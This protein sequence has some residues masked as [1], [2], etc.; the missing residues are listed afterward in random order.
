MEY[1][2][3]IYVDRLNARKRNGLVKVITGLRRSGKSYLLNNLFHRSL[4]ESGVDERHIIKFA[5]DSAEDL[6]IIGEDLLDLE[7]KNSKVDPRKFLEFV[8]DRLID[9]GQYYILL[10]E[11][12]NLESFES[13]LNSYLRKDNLDI[14]ATGSN[15]K[16]LSSDILTEFE[17]RGDEV[18]VFPLSFSEFFSEY[19][20]TKEEAYEEYS[21]YGGLPLVANMRT[22]EQKA[23]YLESLIGKTYVRDI[24]R[25]NGLRSDT[26]M[27]DLLDVVSS[28]ISSIISPRKLESAF[29]SMKGSQISR[30]TIERYTDFFADSFL[31]SKAMRFDIK[32]KKYISA[33]FKLYFEDIGL[34]NAKLGFRQI[35][36]THVMENI[37]YYEL[38]FR[39][40]DVD[41]GVVKSKQ[42]ASDSASVGG[43]EV[44]F[45][46][47]KGSKRYYIQSAY[48][49]PNDEK[50]R[51]E[52]MSLD[53]IGDSFEKIVVVRNPVVSRHSDKGYLLMNIFDFL[54]GKGL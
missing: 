16:F 30:P 48:D 21:L 15:S 47:N 1:K 22:E 5:F 27:S 7:R 9:D 34:R 49:I 8:R 12:Q 52:T 44:D 36:P 28:A 40:F 23:K 4:V 17:A 46:A 33:P 53:R 38:R 35:E 13:V 50:W 45:V 29:K 10:D 54:L 18:H 19:D 14:Y 6:E 42:A 3:E 24:I 26:D 51:Q 41:V 11:V 31:V 37:I 20:G 43:Y 25:H 32:G 39:G 2:R